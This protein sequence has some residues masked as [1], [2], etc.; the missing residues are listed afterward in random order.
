MN[1]KVHKQKINFK[2]EAPAR[3]IIKGSK[4]KQQLKNSTELMKKKYELALLEQIKNGIYN[5]SES[6]ETYEYIDEDGK[7]TDKAIDWLKQFN[8][9]N[10]NLPFEAFREQYEQYDTTGKFDDYIDDWDR[11]KDIT[12]IYLNKDIDD[13][14]KQRQIKEIQENMHIPHEPLGNYNIFESIENKPVSELNKLLPFKNYDISFDFGDLVKKDNNILPEDYYALLL[15]KNYKPKQINENPYYQNGHFTKKGALLYRSLT[16]KLVKPSEKIDDVITDMKKEIKTIEN[17]GVDYVENM[18][19][20]KVNQLTLNKI[21]Q[22]MTDIN[23]LININV[24]KND[25]EL[26]VR[27]IEEETAKDP[28]L[29]EMSLALKNMH[30]DITK[31]NTEEE[32]KILKDYYDRLNEIVENYKSRVN[33][34]DVQGYIFRH[35]DLTDKQKRV[36]N[37]SVFPVYEQ[38]SR[39]RPDENQEQFINDLNERLFNW[40]KDKPLFENELYKLKNLFNSDVTKGAKVYLTIRHD[41]D[42]DVLLAKYN[43]KGKFEEKEILKFKNIINA[44]DLRTIFKGLQIGK[45]VIGFDYEEVYPD[46]TNPDDFELWGKNLREEGQG[47]I[48]ETLTSQANQKINAL[49]KRIEELEK[50]IFGVY[51]QMEKKTETLQNQITNFDTTK[52]KHV[53]VNEKNEEFEPTEIEKNLNDIMAKR[54]KDI[55]PSED[56]ESEEW[57]EGFPI[58]LQNI[59]AEI[60]KQAQGQI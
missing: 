42:G 58:E 56:E 54:R 17:L 49:T 24:S 16:N 6:I 29:K 18:N 59:I 32:K 43:K 35:S 48:R 4:P 44:D 45:R 52:L 51:Q 28:E 40:I 5:P 21:D 20:Q 33:T 57:G 41:G 7:L 31:A 22:I 10:S 23:K 19:V 8:F 26:I 27:E 50:V 1:I 53:E 11:L 2:D 47:L 13:D 14:E 34:P 15:S 37:K 60:D 55:E 36:L 25:L 12:N 9:I 46:N 38:L 30:K 39:D 3:R